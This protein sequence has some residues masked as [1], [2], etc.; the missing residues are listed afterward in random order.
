[1]IIGWVL[2]A[3]V[4]IATAMILTDQAYHA[5]YTKGYQDGLDIAAEDMVDILLEEKK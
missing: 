3:F 4:V 1:M 5:G 2:I